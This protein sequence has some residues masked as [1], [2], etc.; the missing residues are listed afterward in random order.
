MVFQR[1]RRLD[2]RGWTLMELLVVVA[3]VAILA[4]IAIPVMWGYVRASTVRAGAQEMRTALQQ[5]KQL[6]I[7]TRNTVTL[8]AAPGGYQIVC[9]GA[10]CPGQFWTGTAWTN[11]AT[12]LRLEN[13]VTVAGPNIGFSPLGAAVPAG[14]LTVTGPSGDVL[15]VTVSAA[16]R[17]TT[18]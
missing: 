14:T 10:G 11:A 17:I 12:T 6:A 2:Q 16:G 15:T 13:S 4:A 18:P 3:V 8:Q 1:L 7:T 5:A 9:G